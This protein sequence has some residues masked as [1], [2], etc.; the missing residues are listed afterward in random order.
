MAN[1]LTSLDVRRLDKCYW[2]VLAPFEYR[3][4]AADSNVIVDIPAGFVTDFGSV[5]RLLWQI[6]QPVGGPADKAY[7][8]HD[9]LYQA[10]YVE[11]DHG[12]GLPELKLIDRA[13]ADN[14]LNEAMGVLGVDRLSRWAIYTGVRVGGWKAWDK[15][16]SG[17]VQSSTQL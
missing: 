11:I 3:V 1:F 17:G 13:Y 4:G 7:C 8:V 16:R 9:A 15:H 2:Q 12:N 14:V 10:P 6:I 5:P